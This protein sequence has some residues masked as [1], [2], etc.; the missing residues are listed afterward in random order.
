[1]STPTIDTRRFKDQRWLAA[2]NAWNTTAPGNN[3]CFTITQL[4]D[5]GV[6]GLALDIM[7]DD[8]DSLHLQH[9]HGIVSSKTDWVTVLNELNSWLTNNP[10][11]IVMLFFESYLTGPKPGQ[12]IA[13]P[14]SALDETLKETIGCYKSGKAAQTD[15]VLNRNFS[16]LI[17][18]VDE[19]GNVV[20]TPQRL[21]AF[22]ENEPDEGVQ[23]IFPVMRAVFAE[24][25]HGNGALDINTWTDLRE[26]SNSQNPLTFLNHFGKAPTGSEWERNAPDLI[27]KHAQAFAF[28]FGGRYPNF[29]SLDFINWTTSNPG[30]IKAFESLQKEKNFQVSGFKWNKVNSFGDVAISMGTNKITGFVVGVEKGKGITR[31]I[32]DTRASTS[33][34]TGIQLVNVPGH[35][36]VNMRIQKN[37]GAWESWLTPFEQVTDQND[38]N[39]ATHVITGT[40]I[41]FC[42][43]TSD[44]YGIVDFA[45]AYI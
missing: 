3:Q 2:H 10:R 35:G 40:L 15:A 23:E 31:I 4:L 36:I 37:N 1:M 18:G 20:T 34:I 42:C 6:R 14:L 28:I 38:P 29:I 30:P 11:E 22:I 45:A 44:G 19:T 7:G 43:R 25:E 32:A 26:N 17:D 12:T 21:F 13:T 8:K 41:G 9:G 39:L 16:Y 24:N 33:S 27:I 5:Y